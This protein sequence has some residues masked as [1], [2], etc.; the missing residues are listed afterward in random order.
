MKKNQQ[1]IQVALVFTGLILIIST[2]FYY[3]SIKKSEIQKDLSLKIEKEENFSDERSTTFKNVEYQGYYD[4]DKPFTVESETAFIM[5]KEN[6]DILYM[7]NME[8][9]LH[10]SDGRIVR[11]VSNK[12][13]YNKLTNDCFFEEDVKATDGETLIYAD[14]LDL[15]ATKNYVQIYN[16]VT[17]N[18]ASGQLRADKVYY[19]FDT[20]NFK[21]S[22][23]DEKRIKMKVIK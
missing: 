19:N 11:I 6:P 12:G 23:L 18:H 9:N 8:A 5:S 3:P 1:K 14:N 22:M 17:L 16:N 21:V 13:R 20:K 10:L 2:Y 15:L 7:L 4:F